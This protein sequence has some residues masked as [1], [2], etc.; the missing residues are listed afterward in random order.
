MP[1]QPTGRLFADTLVN[2][3]AVAVIVFLA[4][5]LAVIAEAVYQRRFK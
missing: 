2:A 1:L 4:L 3:G 5:C